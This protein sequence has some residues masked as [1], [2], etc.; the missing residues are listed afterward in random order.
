MYRSQNEYQ[1]RMTCSVRRIGEQNPQPV[2][3]RSQ[4]PIVKN[5]DYMPRMTARVRKLFGPSK[6]PEPIEIPVVVEVPEDERVEYRAPPPDDIPR[7]LKEWDD[8]YG[9]F[10]DHD[11]DL[12]YDP[13]GWQKEE[14]QGDEPFYNYNPGN[15]HPT[16]KRVKLSPEEI[17]DGD[18][19]DEGEKHGFGTLITPEGLKQ[20]YWQ[21]NQ[22]TGWNCN[23]PRN[24][25]IVRYGRFNKGIQEG[26]G[27]SD[28]PK[29]IFHGDFE[30]NEKKYGTEEYKPE[31]GKVQK[32]VGY[33]RNN[34]KDGKG[35]VELNTQNQ[36]NGMYDY[37]YDGEFKNGDSTGKGIIEW[38]N[39]TGKD[40]YDGDVVKGKMD[41]T[42]KIIYSN[43]REYEGEF[44]NGKKH[45]HGVYKLQP[46]EKNPEERVFE[47]TFVNGREHGEG[48]T[49]FKDGHQFRGYYINGKLD[50]ALD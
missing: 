34:R 40:V 4:A 1:P 7:I 18:L 37:I 48:V 45:G 44:K 21:H 15:T 19:N 38:N 41:G 10:R 28:E 23:A 6:P 33:F 8:R 42:G 11:V 47:G 39:N 17:Y 26:I 22:F 14:I 24:S 32:Y 13:K 2:V 27:Y 25:G 20:G 35:R 12:L 5:T 30:N 9:K 31:S 49:T 50:H 46:D 29:T 3:F 43:G 16:G 36:R